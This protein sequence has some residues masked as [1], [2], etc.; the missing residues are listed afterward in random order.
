[1]RTVTIG[2]A[3]LLVA[4]C[5]GDEVYPVAADQAFMSLSSI[6]TPSGMNPLPGG[7]S[8]VS[9]NVEAL[10]G[11]KS[12]EWRFSHGG[13]DIGRIVAKVTPDGEASSKV[14][15][16][17]VNGSAPD[18]KWRN[19]QAKRLIE[20]HIQRLVVEAVDST[21]ENRSFNEDLRRQVTLEVTKASVGSLLKDIN[22]SVDQAVAAD[23]ERQREEDNA[24]PSIETDP[25]KPTT[26]LS[27]FNNSSN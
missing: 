12:M 8:A 14:A 22:S 23:K 9:V 26:D 15:I 1:M 24:L 16:T 20:T 10:P 21:L 6:G 11:E 25:T 3:A 19:A 4:G 5:G 17:Y 13:D 7:L 27:K 18:D 2:L